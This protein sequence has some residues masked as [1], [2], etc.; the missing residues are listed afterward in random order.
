M[1]LRLCDDVVL[2]EGDCAVEEADALL[3]WLR[4]ETRPAVDL[5]DC[6]HLHAALLQLLLALRP[7]LVAAPPDPFIRKI[8]AGLPPAITP[9]PSPAEEPVLP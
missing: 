4:P 2:F 9:S 7:G 1:P 8:L 3:A 6:T 5:S